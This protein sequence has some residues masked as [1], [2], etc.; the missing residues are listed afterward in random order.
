M[1]V[2][3]CLGITNHS[4]AEVVQAGTSTTKKVAHACGAGSQCGRCRHTIRAI[5][6]SERHASDAERSVRP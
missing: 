2:C 6:A 3:L 4:V 5:I 1:I